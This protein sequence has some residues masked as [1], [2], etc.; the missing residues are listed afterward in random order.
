MTKEKDVYRVQKG[1]NYNLYT[2]NGK[3]HNLNGPALTIGEEEWYYVNGENYT[4]AQWSNYVTLY[5]SYEKDS[6]EEEYN[7]A[8]AADSPDGIFIEIK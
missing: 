5:N 6:L 1:E 7:F 2:K 4:C 3:K 8:K